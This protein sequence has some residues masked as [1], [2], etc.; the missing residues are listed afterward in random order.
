MGRSRSKRVPSWRLKGAREYQS[1]KA[2][3]ETTY[4]RKFGI[5][6]E[7]DFRGGIKGN[8][9]M[10]FHEVLVENFTELVESGMVLRPIKSIYR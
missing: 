5:Y 10:I 4:G 7:A 3:G 1:S 8:G 2:H 6:A 9:G